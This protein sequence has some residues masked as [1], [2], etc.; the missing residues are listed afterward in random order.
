M[1]QKHFKIL[2]KIKI[3]TSNKNT[4]NNQIRKKLLKESKSI[5]IQY[6]LETIWTK[7]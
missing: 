1:R 7:F 5:F 6:V 2:F 4:N 3:I